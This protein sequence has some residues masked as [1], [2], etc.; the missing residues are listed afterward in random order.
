MSA[1]NT[2]RA[3]TIAGRVPR[4]GTDGGHH[5]AILC[6]EGGRSK[7]RTLKRIL[8]R[9]S[10]WARTQQDEERLRAEIEEHLALQ[11]ADNIRSGLSPADARR[12][13]VLKFGAVEAV[14]ESYREQR[15][16]PFVETL[17]RDTRHSLR[18]LRMTPAFTVTTVLM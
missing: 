3:Q 18:R 14:K 1:V 11:T 5:G 6:S 10:S 16:L 15:G 8:K 7:M 13:A 17:I 12:Q 4:L 2:R 9:L